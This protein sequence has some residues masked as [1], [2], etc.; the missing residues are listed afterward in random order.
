MIEPIAYYPPDAGIALCPDCAA[1]HAAAEIEANYPAGE[2]PSVEDYLDNLGDYAVALNCQDNEVEGSAPT[3]DHCYERIEGFSTLCAW[4]P[5]GRG[6]DASDCECGQCEAARA[7]VGFERQTA[8]RPA[9]CVYRE[10]DF[11]AAGKIDAA[12]ALSFERAIA[13]ASALPLAR[14]ADRAAALYKRRPSEGRYRAAFAAFDAAHIERAEC[15]AAAEARARA[16]LAKVYTAETIAL[17]DKIADLPDRE[18]GDII[19][20]ALDIVRECGL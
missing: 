18:S 7:L 6:M 15:H 17:A 11:R 10:G 2:G 5:A 13:R 20:R 9:G 3:C 8:D 1:E 16:G 4:E 12:L 19:A 14:A